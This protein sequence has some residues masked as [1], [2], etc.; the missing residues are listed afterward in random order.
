MKKGKILTIAEVK[1]LKNGDYIY[2]VYYNDENEKVCDGFEKLN[3][4]TNVFGTFYD[5]D[6][7]TIPVENYSDDKLIQNLDNSGYRFTI[8]EAILNSKQT[9]N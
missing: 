9:E 3:I 5:A 6:C 4:V 7:Y 2:L 8:Y 1:S